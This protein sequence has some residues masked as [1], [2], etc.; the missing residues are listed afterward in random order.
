MYGASGPDT[1][2]L[3]FTNIALGL[4]TL[5]CVLAIGAGVVRE[6]VARRRRA[7]AAADD[8]AFAT[9]RLGLTMA[10]GGERLDRPKQAPP[11]GR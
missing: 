3:N 1:F 9:P 5:V 2:W 7:A 8:H 4:V 6:L 10:D 11:K